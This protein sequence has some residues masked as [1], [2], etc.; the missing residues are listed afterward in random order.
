MVITPVAAALLITIPAK[1]PG[2]YL[3]TVVVGAAA[4]MFVERNVFIIFIG[5]FYLY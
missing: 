3:T 1:T 4:T 5:E 2:P